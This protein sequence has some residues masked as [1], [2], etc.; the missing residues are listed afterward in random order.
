MIF[1]PDSLGNDRHPLNSPDP[2]VLL[3]LSITSTTRSRLF[4]DTL[5]Y[6]AVHRH[7]GPFAAFTLAF[8]TPLRKPV[9]CL[10]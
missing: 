1:D 8:T 9:R 3:V 6:Q 5:Q 2:K 10:A 7:L 4:A